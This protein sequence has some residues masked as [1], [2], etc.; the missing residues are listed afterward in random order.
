MND[1][2]APTS[3]LDLCECGH[4]A[5]GHLVYMPHACS[6]GVR[7]PAEFSPCIGGKCERWRRAARLQSKS[8]ASR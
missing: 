7:N 5:A 6:V 8:E 4:E 3:E 1:D 2:N